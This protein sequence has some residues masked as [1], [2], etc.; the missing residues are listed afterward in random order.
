MKRLS[1][2]LLTLSAALM[3]YGESTPAKLTIRFAPSDHVFLAQDNRFVG[4]SNFEIQNLVIIN[5]SQQPVKLDEIVI[6]ILS[7]NTPV[8]R[9]HYSG[10]L[11]EKKWEMLRNYITQPGV[12]KN[13]DPRFRFKELLGDEITIS[14]TTTLLPIAIDTTE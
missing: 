11:L 8:Q 5:S 1:L 4:V 14:Q 2:T 13:E 3:L 9:N 6:E 12:M 7:Q 10:F